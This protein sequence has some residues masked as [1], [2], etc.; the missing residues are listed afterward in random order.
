MIPVYDEPEVV[1]AVSSCLLQSWENIEVIVV[2]DGSRMDVARLLSD[3][4]DKRLRYIRQPKNINAN[5]CRNVGVDT[6]R[7]EYISFLDADDLYMRRHIESC[8]MCLESAGVDG[9][10]GSVILHNN[11]TP[12]VIMAEKPYR[13]EGI[14]NY[15]LRK[16]YGACT[17]TLFMTKN[18]ALS[19]RWDESLN[20]HQDYDFVVRFADMFVWTV[21]EEATVIYNSGSRPRPKKIDFFSCIR[22]SQLNRE[23]IIPSLYRCYIM[24]M[25][26]LAKACKADHKII[27]YYENELIAQ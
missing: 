26:N 13:D 25:L 11:R 7:G 6:A 3:I 10:Y 19:V 9:I 12:R 16:G 15:L 1:S 5:V 21:K 18:S 4:T 22:F 14:V 27:R 17:S 24:H 23:N 20:R 8:V 2:D